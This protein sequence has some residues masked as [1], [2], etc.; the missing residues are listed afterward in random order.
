MPLEKMKRTA[1]FFVFFFKVIHGARHGAAGMD[2]NWP[3]GLHKRGEFTG[4]G[5]SHRNVLKN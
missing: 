3:N 4:D 2:G 1:A 5:R